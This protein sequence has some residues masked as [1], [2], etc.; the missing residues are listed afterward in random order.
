V[1]PAAKI[2]RNVIKLFP[3]Y[4]RYLQIIL[5]TR[6]YNFLGY[7][8]KKSIDDVNEFESFY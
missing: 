1:V 7:K 8:V 5:H 2:L 6:R 3:E 4:M